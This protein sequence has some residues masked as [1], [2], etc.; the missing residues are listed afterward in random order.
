[1]GMNWYKTAD[2]A[3]I[4]DCRISKGS[5]I[6]F[7]GRRSATSPQQAETHC[8]YVA[9]DKYGKGPNMRIRIHSLKAQGYEFQ[10]KEVLPPKPPPPKVD[11]QGYLF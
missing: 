1:M 11:P 10:C 7:E 3:R 9:A 4:F 8:W 6:L 2:Q 5:T